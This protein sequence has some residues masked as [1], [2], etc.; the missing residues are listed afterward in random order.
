MERVRFILEVT[1][2]VQTLRKRPFAFDL[3]RYDQMKIVFVDRDLS[4]RT[5]EK[6]FQYNVAVQLEK[7]GHEVKIFTSRMDKERCFPEFLSLPV[8]VVSRG[9]SH[10]AES[11]KRAILHKFGHSQPEALNEFQEF[12][13]PKSNIEAR[14]NTNF[15]F[16]TAETLQYVMQTILTMDMSKKIADTRPDVTMAQHQGEWGLLPF[17]YNLSEPTGVVYLNGGLPRA[18]GAWAPVVPRLQEPPSVRKILDTLLD[19]PP[20]GTWN[21]VSYQKLGLFLA[22]SRFLLEE[23]RGQGVIGQRNA[24]VIPMGVDH[25][26]FFP[27]GEEEPFALFVG[28][29]HPHKSLELAIHAMK[30]TD[31]DKSLIIA[32]PV[33]SSGSGSGAER[34]SWYK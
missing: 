20:A 33:G 19:L 3:K 8:E 15:L 25:S 9:E 32:G 7:L 23:V 2:K 34:F 1:H 24:D 22:P 31:Q 4:V 12:S 27:T 5:G 10:L 17:F 30:D 28:R 29:I 6:R 11:V 18:R 21:K 16:D 26:Q 13:P 14:S